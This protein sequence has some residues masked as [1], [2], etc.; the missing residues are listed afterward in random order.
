MEVKRKRSQ[1]NNISRKM[2]SRAGP[3]LVLVDPSINNKQKLNKIVVKQME[4]DWNESC[5]KI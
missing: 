5:K 1:V 2:A 4:H 3:F